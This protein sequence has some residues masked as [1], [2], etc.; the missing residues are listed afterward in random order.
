[1][2]H[3][4]IANSTGTAASAVPLAF[5]PPLEAQTAT[6]EGMPEQEPQPREPE[7][8][9]VMDVMVFFVGLYLFKLWLSDKADA[10]MGDPHPKAFPGAFTC[11][12]RLFWLGG[13]VSVIIVF[14][15]TAGEYALGISAEQSTVSAIALLAWVA[16]AFVEELIFRG[17]GG[18]TID[19]AARQEYILA[20]HGMALP[21]TANPDEIE[22]TEDGA[23]HAT[24]SAA[25]V[26][27][28]EDV[29]PEV[30]T[31]QD[32]EDEPEAYEEVEIKPA[33]TKRLWTGFLI[34]TLMFITLHPHLWE[35]N[36]AEKEDLSAETLR[37][38]GL[39]PEDEDASLSWS[40]RFAY[41]ELEWHLDS[42]LAW[43]STLI[44]VVNSLFWFWLRFHPMNTKRSLLPC[45][46]GHVAS[47]VAVF[48]VK[49]FQGHVVGIW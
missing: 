1:M 10:L 12:K 35:F 47:N 22:I 41:A 32:S 31:Q 3:P 27:K 49:L 8:D 23:V 16:A 37:S 15:E 4:T 13:V 34:W 14:F 46:V 48:V 29:D 39:D 25:A 5:V 21:M 19:P 38:L 26:I 40:D 36:L 33:S 20:T 7:N 42:A 6:L 2:N 28:S 9:A 44:L 43:W 18:N 11:P 17:I 30:A 45:I 24:G